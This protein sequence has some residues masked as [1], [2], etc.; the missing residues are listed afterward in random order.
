MS[1]PIQDF[2]TLV[3]RSNLKKDKD[4]RMSIDDANKL[5]AAIALLLLELKES[6]NP[7]GPRIIGGGTF[8]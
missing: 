4:I 6:Q 8:K 3:Q 7:K 2:I 1:K 5:H